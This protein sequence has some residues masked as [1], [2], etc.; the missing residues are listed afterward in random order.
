MSTSSTS[1]HVQKALSVAVNS[2]ELV[3]W[4]EGVSSHPQ[5]LKQPRGSHDH[6]GDII[7]V[8]IEEPKWRLS[9]TK[10]VLFTTKKKMVRF[11]ERYAT[12]LD[13]YLQP[14]VAVDLRTETLE[15]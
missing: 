6:N 10:W 9:F 15:R 3:N 2:K 1:P 11:A 14:P 5:Y 4:L 8:M 7:K 12:F 13:G